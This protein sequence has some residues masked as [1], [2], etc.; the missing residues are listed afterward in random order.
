MKLLPNILKKYTAVAQL[1][2]HYIQ[3]NTSQAIPIQ[4]NK[5]VMKE[6]FIV[7]QGCVFR[8]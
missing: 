4:N 7:H 5:H 3:G 2:L 8:K 1:H 6:K